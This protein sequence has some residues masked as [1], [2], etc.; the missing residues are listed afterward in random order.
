MLVGLGVMVT[1]AGVNNENG[2]EALEPLP[3]AAYDSDA[4]SKRTSQCELAPAPE[5]SSIR[6]EAADD[7]RGI[8]YQH[9]TCSS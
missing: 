5:Q 7:Q 9:A 6:E 8:D 4:V 2:M 1:R 3:G